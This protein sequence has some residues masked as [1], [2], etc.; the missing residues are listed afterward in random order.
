MKIFHTEIA[1]LI[2]NLFKLERCGRYEDALAELQ[3]IWE[4]TSKLPDVSEF[5]DQI[6]A[7]IILR[8][9]AVIGF[10]GHNKQISD[11][12]ENSKNL[13]TEA[14]RRFEA[15]NN[16]EKI[17]ECNNY[18]ALAYW[19][20]GELVEAEAWVEENFSYK[21]NRISDVWINCN[22]IK[23]LLLNSNEKY[24]E[25]LTLLRPVENY[26][27]KSG[28]SFLYGVFSANLGIALKDTGKTAE[29]LKYLELSR[30]FHQKSQHLVYLGTTENNLALLYNAIGSFDKAHKAVDNATKVFKNAKDITREGFSFD[31]KA[32]IYF[33]EGE[34]TKALKVVEKG[35]N[36]L[37]KSENIALLV[38]TYLTKA[39]ILLYLDDLTAAFLCLSDAVQIAK[40]NISEERAT[41]LVKE[42]ELALNEK[43][44]PVIN[45]V[46][47]EKEIVEEKIEL[48]LHPSIA[49]YEEFQGVWIKNSHLENYG[50]R[51]GS[52]AVVTKDKIKRGDLV[53]ISENVDGSVLCGFYDADFGI[54][55]LEGIGEEPR[56]FDENDITI[57]GKIIG[58]GNAHNE[59]SGKITVEP[60]KL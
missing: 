12:Q 23:S 14:R 39:K 33:A 11:S 18:L 40:T 32:Q 2:G 28:N 41:T 27:Q 60:L 55:C 13:L 59:T 25:T 53:A 29:A 8:C 3:D 31:T 47:T 46:F 34:Y 43:N 22:L 4:D 10:H 44:S 35:I 16:L 54:V 45:E 7:E 50:L 5:S 58:V 21:L 56:L 30:Y 6:A 49:H 52:L 9:G 15:I 1:V 38:E 17:A 37:T 48:I 36:I 24:E 20:K 42:F 51:K 57:L 26:V 19:R